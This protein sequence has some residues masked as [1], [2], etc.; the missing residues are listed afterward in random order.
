MKMKS[1]TAGRRLSV[2]L[3]F[4]LSFVFLAGTVSARPHVF[5][6]EV[7]QSHQ[8]GTTLDGPVFFSGNN[9]RIDG[10]VNGMTFASGDHVEVSGDINGSLFV[11]TVLGAC[12]FQ[13][14]TQSIGSGVLIL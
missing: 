11:I 3:F 14:R 13:T 5:N 2:L 4:L 9:V 7:R 10:E 12:F 8:E 6:R 1:T